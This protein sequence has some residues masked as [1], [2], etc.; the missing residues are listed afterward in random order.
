[1]LVQVSGRAMDYVRRC[2]FLA[3]KSLLLK[4]EITRKVPKGFQAWKPHLEPRGRNSLLPGLVQ[5]RS[6]VEVL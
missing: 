3:T 2:N 1:M 4:P 6:Q 5:S